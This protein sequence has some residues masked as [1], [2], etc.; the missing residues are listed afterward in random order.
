MLWLRKGFDA[1]LL[2][3]QTFYCPS[4]EGNWTNKVSNI[5]SPLHWLP[6]WLLNI[7]WGV[8]YD[9]ESSKPSA[10]Y[11]VRHFFPCFILA[12][13]NYYAS[14]NSSYNWEMRTV[15]EPYTLE[16]TTAQLFLFSEDLKQ[17]IPNHFRNI[18]FCHFIVP[19]PPF[20]HHKCFRDWH[21]KNKLKLISFWIY[22]RN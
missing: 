9:Y 13:E 12:I 18:I 11:I 2:H 20:S 15:V 3:A 5:C 14:S 22:W 17:V 8:D 10:F 1:S 6:I 4:A 16:V 21:F 7:I 19:C